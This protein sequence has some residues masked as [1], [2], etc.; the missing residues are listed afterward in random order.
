LRIDLASAGSEVHVGRTRDAEAQR[1][2]VV[3]GEP[4]GD[5]RASPAQT[6]AALG[7]IRQVHADHA[8]MPEALEPLLEGGARAGQPLAAERQRSEGGF[9]EQPAVVPLV[10]GPALH[11]AVPAA[12]GLVV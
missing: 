4:V 5:P 11:H 2:G 1:G 7:A 6:H 12:H 9:E 3:L 8:Q 10:H